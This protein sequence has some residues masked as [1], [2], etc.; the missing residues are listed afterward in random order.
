M[1]GAAF[2]VPHGL[3]NAALISHVIRYNATDAPAKQAAFPQ[4]QYPKAKQQYA[5]LASMLGLGGATDDDKVVALIEAVEEL[6]R[7]C[8]V[9]PTIREILNSAEAEEQ[10]LART[11]T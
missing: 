5:E 6:K 7:Q 1:A 4:Y 2:H 10:F 8:D 9:P 3:A 11:A